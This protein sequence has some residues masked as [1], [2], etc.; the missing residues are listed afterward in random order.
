MASPQQAH[1]PASTNSEAPDAWHCRTP[2]DTWQAL[3]S[4]VE[5]LSQEEAA[6]R[7]ALHGPNALREAAAIRPLD[8]LLAQFKSPIVLILGAAGAITGFL[9]EWIDTLAILG[10]VLLNGIVGFYQEYGAERSIQALKQM[11]APRAKVRRGGVTVVR[12][13]SEL[14][15]GDVLE[16]EAG[17]LVPADARLIEA[18]ALRCVEAALTGEAEGVA[19]HAETLDRREIPLGDRRNLVFMG[20]SVVNGSALALVVDTGMRTE[21]GRIAALLTIAGAAEDIAPLQRRLQQLAKT[22]ILF[23]V[24][25]VGLIFALGLWRQ[26]PPVESFMTSVSLAVA[27]IPEG[28]PTIVTVALA[29]GVQRMARRRALIRSLPAV[30]TLGG[31]HVIATDK[32]GT[33]TVGEMT[34]RRAFT[35]G[36]SFTVTGEGYGPEGTVVPEDEAPLPVAVELLT[37]LAGCCNAHLSEE[38][39]NWEV[40]GDPTEGALLT[41]AAKVGITTRA[42]DHSHPRKAE[43]PFDSERKCMTVVRAYPQGLRALVKGAPDVILERCTRILTADGERPLTPADR[44][45]VLEA[46]AEMG[47]QALRVLGA[48]TR[49]VSHEA[50]G[51]GIEAIESDLTFVGLVG[52]QDPPR[53]EAREAVGRCHTAGIEVVMITGDHP[54]TALA[55][56]RDLGIAERDDQLLTG[57]E[58]DRLDEAQLAAQVERIRVYAR[59]SAEHKLRIVRAWQAQGSTIAMTGDGVNDAPAIR[60]AD[61]GISMGRTGTEVTKEASDMVILDDNFATIV[62][63]VEEG[64]GIFDNIRKAINYLLA[65]N[66]AEL[67]VITACVLVG[68]P[69][70]LLPIHLLWINLITDGL[71]ALGL[72][73]DPVDPDVMQRPPRRADVSMTNRDFLLTGGVAS[74]LTVAVVLGVYV[75]ALRAFNE[76]VART[77]A[78][79]TLVYAELLRAFGARSEY[80]P[81]WKIAGRR[82]TVLA[83]IVGLSLLIQPWNYPFPLVSTIFQTTPLAWHESGLLFLMGAIPLV[84]IELLKAI[85]WRRRAGRLA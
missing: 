8:I 51:P 63:A 61:V 71:P 11:S 53:P 59:V 13:A 12:P 35:A 10:I 83:L 27:A 81:I 4:Q 50:C 46:N 30:E 40:I 37:V 43:L 28:M 5:G 34:V 21:I 79:A 1:P 31:T 7:L 48:A 44:Q 76:E 15:P 82:N 78:F 75:Y 25:I 19:K 72:A 68:L 67:G 2:E 42:L 32:T 6:R 49:D 23:A 45:A 26:I 84:G 55:I 70:P 69:M 20:T 57:L 3:D 85:R 22:L 65:G 24:G 74:A 54:Q 39:G 66:L 58:L 17:D 47:R 56:A 80:K 73:N 16:L 14:V 41:A 60:G 38:D 29:L 77:C 52:M 64:R 9:G 36:G 33:L 62:A 18:N